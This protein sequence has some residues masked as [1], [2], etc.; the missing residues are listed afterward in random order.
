MI[1]AAEIRALRGEWSLD[2]HV[3]EKD[4][5]LGWLLAG[6]AGHHGLKNW[7]FKGGTCLRKC[8]FE[9]YRFSED[10]DFTVI[11]EPDEPDQLLPIFQ[12]IAETIYDSCGL[13]LL[14]NE[15]SFRR[16]KN[17]RGKPTTEG[18]IAFIGPMGSP[19]VPKVKLDVTT[20]ELVARPTVVRPAFHAYADAPEQT[21]AGV[22]IVARVRSY[23]LV[24]LMAEKLRA[25]TE[26]CRPRDLYDV[27]HT[28]RHPGLLGQAREVSIALA[29]K[30]DFAGIEVPTLETVRATPFRAEIEAEWANM[31]AHQL[32][33]LPAFDGFWETLEDLFGWLSGAV[34]MPH[35]EPATDSTV[36]GEWKAPRTMTSWRTGAPL[37]LIR[38]AGAN[39]LKVEIDYRAER[40]R[41]GSRL[42]EPYSLRRSHD[43]DLLLFVLNDH[44][45]LRSYRVD[46]IVGVNVTRQSF[47]PKFV[48]EF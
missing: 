24:E 47:A 23:S 15:T 29:E 30:C 4:Y 25:L 20:D 37:E 48:V 28:H 11:D 40:G 26:R 35:L 3:I 1:S 39:R 14:A 44:H 10:L 17:R 36:S 19:S 13:R 45:Q 41:R 43:G 7:I 34:P 2:V 32:P 21:D 22:G 42:V 5:V 31:L 33:E 8:Y 12:E 18:K 6:I 9:T 27:I 46:R 16:R 38:F